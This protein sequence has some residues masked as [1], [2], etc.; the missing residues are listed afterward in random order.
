MVGYFLASMLVGV[1]DA[2]VC[3]QFEL[4]V[5]KLK[6]FAPERSGKV[7]TSFPMLRIPALIDSLTI[8]KQRE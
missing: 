8:V 4:I 3:K 2:G 5:R 6:S 1:P 7:S